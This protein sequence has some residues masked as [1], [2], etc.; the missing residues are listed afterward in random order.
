MDLFLFPVVPDV[1]DVV[2]VLEN[3]EH[4]FHVGDVLGLIELLIVLRDHLDLRGFE[5]VALVLERLGDVVEVVG[6]GVDGE[7]ASSS[8]SITMTPFLS[9]AQLT[10]PLTPRLPPYLSK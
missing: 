9:N 1:L 4:L 8:L 7:A 6:V 10:Q 5:L 3:V 2:V